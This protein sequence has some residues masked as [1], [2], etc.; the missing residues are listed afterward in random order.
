MVDSGCIWR[1]DR[2]G[3]DPELH[4]KSFFLSWAAEGLSSPCRPPRASGLCSLP[5]P[6]M[7]LEAHR[8][9]SFSSLVLR[10]GLH[11]LLPVALS[12]GTL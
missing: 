4:E 9:S 12:S 2:Q 6:L 5:L 10:A 7:H 8:P 3:L 1:W 11:P